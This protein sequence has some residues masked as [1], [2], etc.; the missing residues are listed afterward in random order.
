[1]ASSAMMRSLEAGG[2]SVEVGASGTDWTLTPR[3]ALE[4]SFDGLP[5]WIAAP[6]AE[7]V[8]FRVAIGGEERVARAVA[9]GSGDCWYVIETPPSV[10]LRLRVDAGDRV[11]M[12][13]TAVVTH[14]RKGDTECSVLD[15]EFVVP[16]THDHAG[17]PVTTVALPEGIAYVHEACVDGERRYVLASFTVRLA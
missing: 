3:T 6:D 12:R 10:P 11:S 15:G 1:M 17:V 13:V 5:E 7:N 8:R 2:F 4:G 16:A 9:T 14:P